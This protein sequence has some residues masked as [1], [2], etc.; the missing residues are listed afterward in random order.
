[1]VV[2][3]SLSVA[4]IFCCSLSGAIFFARGSFLTA[5]CIHAEKS[6]LCSLT[7]W[8]NSSGDMVSRR[9]MSSGTLLILVPLLVTKWK[10]VSRFCWGFGA[11]G[12][13]GIGCC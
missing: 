7:W 3:A 4:M 9:V 6:F 5:W 2:S 10:S 1:V 11:T 12:V 13:V 8:E